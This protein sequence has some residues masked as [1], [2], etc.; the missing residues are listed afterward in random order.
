MI[1]LPVRLSQALGF[2]FLLSL[3]LGIVGGVMVV[4]LERS[5]QED[6]SQE[7]DALAAAIDRAIAPGDT[8]T[9]DQA[10]AVEAVSGL[11]GTDPGTSTG[12][13]IRVIDRDGRTLASSS[14]D[15]DRALP[16]LLALANADVASQDVVS[17]GRDRVRLVSR[18]VVRDGVV[19]G[20]VQVG[21]S[22]H[23]LDAT[24]HRMWQLLSAAAVLGGLLSLVGGWWLSARL[25]RSIAAITRTAREIAETGELARR[26]QEPIRRDEIGELVGTMNAM[27]DRLDRAARRQRDF[28]ADVSHELRGPLTVIRG[29][30]DLLRLD[31]PASDRQESTSEA[32][33]EVDRM[34]RLVDDLLFL[35][36][37]DSSE[38]VAHSPVDL[39]STVITEIER[40][41]SADAG[42]H[43]IVAGPLD[44]AT[45]KGDRDRLAQLVWNLLDNAR[46]YTPAGG[47]IAV[48]LRAFGRLVELTV[49]DTG[50]GIAPEHLPRIFDR[51]YRAD[52]A[53]SRSQGGTGLGLSIVRQVTEAHGGQV[54]ARS[55]PGAGATFT[56]VLPADGSDDLAARSHARGRV[57]ATER[58]ASVSERTKD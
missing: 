7:L 46:K 48:S 20:V 50:M 13:L 41:Q 15:L 33:S 27:L 35:T 17:V 25:F 16:S 55:E 2:A 40:A 5:L 57:V 23:L 58:E 21:E 14:P 1:S 54:R 3:T 51:F 32:A 49:T 30:L 34:N 53:R 11:A 37:I 19:I 47:R 4:A 36:E 18:P 28:L 8:T 45:V 38:M 24:V 6:M 44:A 12:I 43:E 39:R 22:L 29:N 42:V 9:L 52:K 31:L 10:L 56:V 26:L